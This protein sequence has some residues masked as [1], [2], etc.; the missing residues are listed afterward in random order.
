MSIGG[1]EGGR[2]K[3]EKKREEKK[4]YVHFIKAFKVHVHVCNVP[5]LSLSY[6]YIYCTYRNS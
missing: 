2:E 3:E 6:T 4:I 5:P 1:R